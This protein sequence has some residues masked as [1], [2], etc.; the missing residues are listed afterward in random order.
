MS[1]LRPSVESK[2]LSQRKEP[3]MAGTKVTVKIAWGKREKK[4][5]I[6]LAAPTLG[7]V[8]K[9]LQKRDDWGQFDGVG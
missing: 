7:G 2:N 3:A 5:S 6:R 4:S 9:E 1:G 8:L